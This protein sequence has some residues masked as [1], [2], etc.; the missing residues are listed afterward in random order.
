MIKF[1]YWKLIKIINKSVFIIYEIKGIF[2]KYIVVLVILYL[3]Y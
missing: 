1:G 3:I 2:I